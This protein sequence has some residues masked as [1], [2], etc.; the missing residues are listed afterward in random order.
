MVGLLPAISGE[1]RLGGA[2]L[3]QYDPDQLGSLIGYLPQNVTLFSGTVAENIA[4]MSV[5][6]DEEK[7]FEAAKRANAHE[8]ILKLPE[9]DKTVIHA[10]DNQLSGGQKQ[11]LALARAL[12]QNPVILVLDEPNSALDSVGTEALNRTVREFKSS[13]RSVVIMTHRPQAISEC[14]RLIVM[15]S[16]RIKANGPRDEVLKAMLKNAGQVQREIAPE[17]P[18]ET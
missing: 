16:G 11:R 18:N 6:V 2:T 15:D 7:V 5:N 1:T 14:D 8:M 9:G 13:D 12:Y 17:K 3:D 10:N 4:R